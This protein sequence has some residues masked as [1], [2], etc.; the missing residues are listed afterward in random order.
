[1]EALSLARSGRLQEA[2]RLSGAAVDI[3]ARAEE[4]ERAALFE[5]A[6]AI[7]EAF[8]GN[9]AAARQSAARALELGRGRDSDYAVAF[10]LALSGDLEQ[11][12]VL[13][14]GLAR[15]FPEA[16]FVQS[17]YLPTLRALAA[18]RTPDPAAA[19]ESLRTA[20]RYD[21]ALGGVGFRGWFGG[22]YQ[23]YVRGLAYLAAGQAAEAAGEFQRIVDHRSIVLVD[24]LDAIARLHLAR[25]LLRSGDR[26]RARSTYDDLL[27]LWHNADDGI[28]LVEEA[29]A[30]RARLQ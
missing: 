29:R 21:L 28:P 10:A 18:L 17:M 5:A 3:A 24:P 23:V 1:V 4:D 16:T 7:S 2:R 13:A 30:E 27:A 26:D 22:L 12:Q 25:A 9:A 19:I 6:N 15:E 8:Y 11:S 14:E 20:S